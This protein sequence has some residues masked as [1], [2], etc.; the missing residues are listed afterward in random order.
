MNK[1]DCSLDTLILGIGCNLY[2]LLLPLNFFPSPPSCIY[3]YIYVYLVPLHF[4][5][6]AESTNESF[7]SPTSRPP[8]QFFPF[9]P[10]VISSITFQPSPRDSKKKL[11]VDTGWDNRGEYSCLLSLLLS[12]SFLF[13]LNWILNPILGDRV[14]VSSVNNCQLERNRV[15]KGEGGKRI[16]RIFPRWTT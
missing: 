7:S 15:K 8:F 5:N 9:I 10:I 12:S 1:C 13:F 16:K 6:R 2:H 14:G 4:V 11:K 3:I